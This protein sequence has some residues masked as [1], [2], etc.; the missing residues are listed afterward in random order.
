M[1]RRVA[2]LTA[3]I[4]LGIVIAC[5]MAGSTYYARVTVPMGMTQEISQTL[6][7]ATISALNASGTE[8]AIQ[9]LSAIPTSTP[10]PSPTLTPTLIPQVTTC[11]AEVVGTSRALYPVPGQGH[12]LFNKIIEAGTIVKV[13]GRLSDAGWYKTEANNESGWM[14][15]NSLKLLNSCRPTVF[16]LHYLANWLSPDEMLIIDDTFSSNT[17]VWI[18]AASQKN[19]LV[20]TTP[21]GEAI[22]LIQSD[23]ERIITTTNPRVL[24]ISAFKLFTSLTADKVNN[25][26]YFGF[27]FRDSG[28]D[29]YQLFFSPKS[30]KVDIYATN[31]LVFSNNINPQIC[32]DR[33]YDIYLSLSS[34]YKLEIQINGFDPISVS[35]QDPSG[36]YAS[37]KINFVTN[38]IDTG[39]DYIVIT[40]PK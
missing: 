27:R 18:D 20:N 8:S 11:D 14:K 13:V 38:D 1:N 6:S 23:N 25:E 28:T 35:L 40:T 39:I 26:S 21:Q 30:C 15:S 29:Y 24:N 2:I 37:G 19:I 12:A 22:L 9:T 7:A 33:Y 4:C 36:R 16:D 5:V 31:E 10:L 34:D 32:I 17:N 3:L